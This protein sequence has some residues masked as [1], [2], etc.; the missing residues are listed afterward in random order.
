MIDEDLARMYKVST[1]RSNEQV[2][3]NRDRFPLDFMFQLNEKEWSNSLH[4]QITR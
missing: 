4:P 2:E 3:R 1:K